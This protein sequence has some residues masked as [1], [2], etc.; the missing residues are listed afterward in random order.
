MNA[1]R[2]PRHGLDGV[3]GLAG[4][5]TDSAVVEG[6]HVVP[7]GDAVHDSRVPVVQD[8][9]EVGEQDHRD[10]ASR[11]Q[12]AVGEV[13]AAGRDRAGGGVLVRGVRAVSRRLIGS[14]GFSFARKRRRCDVLYYDRTSMWPSGPA[15]TRHTS[16]AMPNSA[17]ELR[18]PCSSRASERTWSVRARESWRVP[19]IA[20]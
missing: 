19:T 4:R 14:H 18:T 11:A 6:D 20:A 13:D 17:S 12:F 15:R 10:A 7:G 9:G 5:P 16:A 3:R 2:V 8:G 1:D